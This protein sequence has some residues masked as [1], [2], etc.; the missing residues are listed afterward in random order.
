MEN[1]LVP[2]AGF[3]LATLQL[4]ALPRKPSLELIRATLRA[5]KGV[6]STVRILKSFAPDLVVG[7]GGYVAGPVLLAAA[8]MGYKTLIHE[9]NAFPS[10]TNRWLGRFVDRVAVSHHKASDFF[11]AAK[12]SVTGNPLR[13]DILKIDPTEAR[14][15]LGLSPEAKV[16]VVVGGSGGALRLNQVLCDSY[17]YILRQGITLYHVTGNNYFEMV[18][19]KAQAITSDKLKVINYADNMP[20]LLAAADLVVSRAGSI[21]AELAVLG[22]P[23]ILVPSPIAANDHQ[24]HNAL[25]AEQ[26]GAAVLLRDEHLNVQSLTEL[27]DL[28][29]RTPGRLGEMGDKFR[30]LALPHATEAI[31]ELMES[32]LGA[33]TS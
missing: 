21:T 8:L 16:L 9:Q 12:V 20:D 13:P 26:A 10:L 28:L 27:L 25:V 18:N 14:L 6:L 1:S 22:K 3:D 30:Q 32:L 7:T 17:N 29:F 15:R 4:T 19:S 33:R 31:C 23:A 24:T 5:G 2:A 11:P